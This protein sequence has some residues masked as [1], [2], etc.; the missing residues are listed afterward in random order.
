MASSPCPLLHSSFPF[1]SQKPADCVSLADGIMNTEKALIIEN[2]EFLL[3]FNRKKGFRNKREFG[4]SILP[5]EA[6]TIASQTI[7]LPWQRTIFFHLPYCLR[8]SG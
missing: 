5:L 1:S 8:S 7:L 3:S 4:T 6:A 2:M